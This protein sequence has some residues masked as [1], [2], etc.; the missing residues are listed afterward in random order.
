MYI[1]VFI[2]STN[3]LTHIG[4]SRGHDATFPTRIL[5]HNNYKVDA[6]SRT[7]H[8][9]AFRS[10]EILMNVICVLVLRVFGVHKLLPT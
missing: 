3:K 8:K 2:Y 1:Y 7:S 6:I 4:I 5:N 10:R 9:R